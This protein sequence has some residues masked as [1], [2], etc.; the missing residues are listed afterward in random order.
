VS[1]HGPCSVGIFMAQLEIKVENNIIF[2]FN[3]I[4]TEIITLEE[5]IFS[6]SPR[7][8]LPLTPLETYSD[9]D[10]H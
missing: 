7:S 5:F 6:R 1:V 3:V 4:L 8:P 2:V 9:L 10:L